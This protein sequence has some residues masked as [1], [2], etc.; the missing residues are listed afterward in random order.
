MKS[1]ELKID[2]SPL[3]PLHTIQRDVLCRGLIEEIEMFSD[4]FDGVLFFLNNV[5]QCLDY[6]LLN[7]ISPVRSDPTKAWKLVEGVLNTIFKSANEEQNR[8]MRRLRQRLKFHICEK[9][10]RFKSDNDPLLK[11][12][13]SYEEARALLCSPADHLIKYIPQDLDHIEGLDEEIIS[14]IEA[15]TVVY[16]IDYYFM[17]TEV[18]L[19]ENDPS[20]LLLSHIAN[21]PTKIDTGCTRADLRVLSLKSASYK[22]G[23]E[24]EFRKIGCSCGDE[25]SPLCPI[26]DYIS[27]LTHPLISFEVRMIKRFPKKTERDQHPMSFHGRFIIAKTGRDQYLSSWY[28]EK[29]VNLLLE[30][31]EHQNTGLK[32][33]DVQFSRINRETT[34]R[35]LANFPG[36]NNMNKEVVFTHRSAPAGVS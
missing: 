16:I 14:L 8:Q 29:G 27:N 3:L 1:D 18:A 2:Q 12:E 31:R 28:L 23:H 19:I 9:S 13:F 17:K 7:V 15:S 24:G 22:Q 30:L 5:Y 11:Y 36:D 33:F 10:A 21:S 32:R 34:E 25:V 4:Y 20:A 35:L 6:N 26:T